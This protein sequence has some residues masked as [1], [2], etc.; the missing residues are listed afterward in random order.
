MG[1]VAFLCQVC[2]SLSLRTAYLVVSILFPRL[3]DI[4]FSPPSIELAK[5]LS[6]PL[7]NILNNTSITSKMVVIT[8]M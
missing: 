1:L 4:Y 3:K 8:N 5:D 7:C 6:H 2:S